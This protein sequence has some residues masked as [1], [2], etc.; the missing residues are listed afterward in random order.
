MFIFDLAM[1]LGKT[2]DELMEN[3]TWNE[4]TYWIAYAR[5]KKQKK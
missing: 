3:L 4:L 1:Q 5:I 2:V